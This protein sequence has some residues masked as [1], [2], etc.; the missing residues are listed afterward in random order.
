LRGLGTPVS[1][2]SNDLR[3]TTH[4]LVTR[5]TI[6]D[7]D[8][9]VAGLRSADLRELEDLSGRGARECLLFGALAG[10]P[11]Y[12]LRTHSGALVGQ[13][14]VT[15]YGANNGLIALSGTDQLERTPM[16]FLRGSRDVLAAMEGSYDTLLNVCDARNEVH[17]KW[18]RWLGFSFLREI[19][20]FGPRGVPVYEFARIRK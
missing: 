6:Q 19:K 13:V 3:L 11:C 4:G 14:S 9:L 12:T 20:Q 10:K 7:V 8:E 2:A 15:P 1:S 5:T 17:V 16:A 18:L